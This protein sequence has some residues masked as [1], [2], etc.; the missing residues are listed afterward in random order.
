MPKDVIIV[1]DDTAVRDAICDVLHEV[2]YAVAA[3]ENGRTALE[4]LRD[5][6]RPCLILLD[7]MMPVMD[8]WAFL[9]E[10]REDP[11][12]A[13]IPVAVLSAAG[14]D[15]LPP[16][17][18]ADHFLRKPFEMSPLLDLVARACCTGH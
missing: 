18:P 2:G 17:V 15:R 6:N 8:G 7:L 1:E 10:R 14:M 11:K 9:C 13:E 5:G 16:D 4:Y 12:L 3:F